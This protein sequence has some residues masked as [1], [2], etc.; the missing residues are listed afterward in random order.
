MKYIKDKD[1]PLALEKFLR[2]EYY[3]G[4]KEAV[5]CSVTELFNPPK[6]NTL[7]RKHLDDIV[8]PLSRV[9]ASQE[10][11]AFHKTMEDVLAGDDDWITEQRIN[12]TFNG[13]I[14]SGKFDAYH[15]PT[16]T[17]ID[18]KNTWYYKLQRQ[19][20]VNQWYLQL[21]IYAYMWRKLG[22]EVD[23]IEVNYILKDKA[24]KFSSWGI[25]SRY[26]K[27]ELDLMTDFQVESHVEELLSDL[28]YKPMR[29][30]TDSER[31]IKMPEY[32]IYKKGSK[33]ASKVVKSQVEVKMFMYG[34]DEEDYIV[35]KRTFEPI[36]CND[37]CPVREYCDQANS[38]TKQLAD[39][40]LPFV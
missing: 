22:H 26:G 14:V 23:S 40:E 5:Y 36:R 17:L 24:N 21:N 20:I 39:D 35:D 19:D 30:C 11:S 28:T 29:D 1:Y 33:R 10:G 16:K 3:D 6:I 7:K 18:F 2:H 9:E 27:I 13:L 8:L 31:W 25:D 38:D 12:A 34:K 32:A 4:T 15:K 37:W